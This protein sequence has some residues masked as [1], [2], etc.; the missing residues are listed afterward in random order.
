MGFLNIFSG[1]SPEE[2]E[3]K[4][5]QYAENSEY[6]L[7][8]I[9]YQKAIDKLEKK[10]SG[11]PGDK[12]QLE[13]KVVNTKE[14]LARLHV[15]N[16]NK[17]IASEVFDEAEELFDLA[18]GLTK[19][20]DLVSEI[21]KKLN[22]I[23]MELKNE[24]QVEQVVIEKDE[25]E[26]EEFIHSEDEYF[27]AIVNSLPPEEN[28]AYQAYGDNFK[29]GYVLLHNGDFAAAAE[30]LSLAMDENP[31]EKSLIP[32]E[33]AT[34]KTNLGLLDEALA[35]LD[36]FIMKHPGSTRAYT[37]ICE[38]LWEREA[39]D[40]AQKLLCECVPEIS[41]SVPIKILKGETFFHQKKFDEAVEIYNKVLD[42][43][44]WDEHISRFLAK[45]YEAS[46]SNEAARDVYCEILGKCQGCGKRPDPQIMLR[47]AETSFAV[48]DYST[49]ILE[50]Y[51]NLSKTDTENRKHYFKKIS[52]IYSSQGNEKEA[53]RFS[54]FSED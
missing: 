25:E 53:K 29:T 43:Q 4:G 15:E 44:G 34:A 54:G 6:G 22:E 41:G 30:K 46:G 17:L 20:P 31:D 52:E 9:E 36:S 42:E 13:K 5:D 10:D 3:Q 39:F 27:G 2:L 35:L 18:L 49:G 11:N 8:I 40:R 37:L 50:I 24:V 51:L 21:E 28:K 38:I 1:K 19:E 48:G 14:S 12:D 32:L 7:A 16:G 26:T 23:K 33:L 47:Y 45:T